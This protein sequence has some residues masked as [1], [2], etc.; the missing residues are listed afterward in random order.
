MIHHTVILMECH[1]DP[2]DSALDPV[3]GFTRYPIV[4]L[5]LANCRRS[6]EMLFEQV[7]DLEGKKRKVLEKIN[8]IKLQVLKFF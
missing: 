6:F 3:Q 4:I 8:M 5:Q 2:L 7:V 1:I